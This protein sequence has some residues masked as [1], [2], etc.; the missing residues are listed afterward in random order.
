MECDS[1][2]VLQCGPDLQRWA[3]CRTHPQQPSALSPRYARSV[4]CKQPG[5]D[6]SSQRSY[7]SY[8][9]YLDSHASRRCRTHVSAYRTIASLD[10]LSRALHGGISHPEIAAPFEILCCRSFRTRAQDGWSISDNRV[11]CR[12][13]NSSIEF[14]SQLLSQEEI[15]NEQVTTHCHCVIRG[16]DVD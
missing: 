8:L 16:W 7:A 1:S 15:C 5:S 14:R 13:L 10:P 12:G 6:N 11:R 4:G 2:C 9:S 3:L